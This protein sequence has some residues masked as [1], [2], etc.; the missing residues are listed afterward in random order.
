MATSSAWKCAEGKTPGTRPR[1]PSSDLEPRADPYCLKAASPRMSLLPGSPAL[2]SSAMAP[3]APSA[4]NDDDGVRRRV[5]GRS[6]R[7]LCLTRFE[8]GDGDGVQARRPWRRRT[9][10]QTRPAVGAVLVDHREAFCSAVPGEFHQNGGLGDVSRRR[11][12]VVPA[13]LVLL[14]SGAVLA[15]EMSVTL[16]LDSTS[17]AAGARLESVGPITTSALASTS[18]RA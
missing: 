16:A 6:R 4:G 5:A 17:M 10:L 14:S 18:S 3:C 8:A 2:V 1:A 11:A 12:E 9:L 15:G 7:L 13:A